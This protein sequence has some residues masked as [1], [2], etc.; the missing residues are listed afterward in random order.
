MLNRRMV[1]LWGVL[2]VLVFPARA[3]DDAALQQQVEMLQQRVT[4]LER[5][6]DAIETPQ[7]KQAIRS[8]AGPEKPG[9]STEAS[10]WDFLKVGYSYDKVRELL[11]EPVDIKR[12]AMEFWFYSDRGLKGPF[13]KFLFKQVNSW[14][15]PEAQ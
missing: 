8:A 12:G 5:R 11:G 14:K 2:W 10:N 1:F 9:D 6:L 4:E 15:G 13:V 7:I 3:A